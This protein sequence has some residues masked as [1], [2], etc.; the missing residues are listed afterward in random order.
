MDGLG[1]QAKEFKLHSKDNRKPMV[2]FEH[3]W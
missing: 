1:C 3:K 2:F